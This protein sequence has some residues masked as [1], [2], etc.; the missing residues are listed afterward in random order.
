MIIMVNN[1]FL[2]YDWAGRESLG[3][4][5]KDK[6]GIFLTNESTRE[7]S[8]FAGFFGGSFTTLPEAAAAGAGAEARVG[9]EEGVG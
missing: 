6:S 4:S 9:A 7:V 3:E 1:V 5:I 8:C 2:F